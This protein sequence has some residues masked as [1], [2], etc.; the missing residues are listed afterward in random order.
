MF[1]L[2]GRNPGD[3]PALQV[4]QRRRN[5]PPQIRRLQYASY[6]YR[7]RAQWK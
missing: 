3:N 4:A 2:F 6:A 5:Q 7:V 1:L